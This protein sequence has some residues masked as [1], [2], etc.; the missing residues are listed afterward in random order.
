M[1]V[2]N[3]GKNSRKPLLDFVG[4]LSGKVCLLDTAYYAIT[5]IMRLQLMESVPMETNM[6]T[7]KNHGELSD[8]E[9]SVRKSGFCPNLCSSCE[10][11]NAREAR[12]RRWADPE[13]RRQL[14]AQNAT[15]RS[16]K[17]AKQAIPAVVLPPESELFETLRE[18]GLLVDLVETPQKIQEALK[19]IKIRDPLPQ[20]STG[21]N[22]L[23][24]HFPHRFNARTEGQLSLRESL[25]DDAQLRRVTNYIAKSG[26]YP[27][28]K[29]VLRNLQFVCMTPSHFFP[30]AAAALC[31]EF[32][33]GKDV[34]DP[35]AGWGG[36]TLGAL[37]SNIRTFTTTDLQEKSV[38]GCLQISR[39]FSSVPCRV[40]NQDFAAYM[41]GMPKSF[42]LILTSPPFGSTEDY[43]GEKLNMRSW[44]QSILVP[45]VRLSQRVLRF[46][47]ILAIHAQ[48]RKSLPI[49]SMVLGTCLTAGFELIHEFKYGKKPGQAVLIFKLME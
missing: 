18:D 37:C 19:E 45:L 12:K 21:L 49:L 42:D 38:S 35:F 40:I 32:G 48:D 10:R 26:R 11:K 4:G 3:T 31:K 8:S 5:V 24:H 36:R 20:T 2:Q 16:K 14:A 1:G 7:C 17:A 23:D 27:T 34:F 6:R 47:G 44:V 29:L 46:D 9:F 13:Q 25:S 30:S 28:K 39:D 33:L 22:Y 41:V 43:G 15:W